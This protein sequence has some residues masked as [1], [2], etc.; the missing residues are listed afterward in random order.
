MRGP[1]S[2]WRDVREIDVLSRLRLE[3][4]DRQ[5][6]Q[7]ER[8]AQQERELTRYGMN[9]F[10]RST[11]ELTQS[12]QG[13]VPDDYQ[14]VPGD[15]I[16]AIFTNLN[17]GSTTESVVIDESGAANLSA[18]G[19]LALAGLTRAHA[20]SALNSALASTRLR[21]M[22]A[23]IRVIEMQKIR[24]FVVGEA[25][26]PGGYLLNTSSTVLDALLRAGGPTE[27]GSFRKIQL[28]RHGR[29][30]AT[31]DLYDLLMRGRVGSPRLLQG[32]RVFIP[33]AGEQIS[34]IGEVKRPAIYE[35]KSER[36][37]K[38]A[39]ALAG[40]LLPEAYSPQ[41][42]IRRISKNNQR[43]LLDVPAKGSATAIMP[44]DVIVVRSVLDDLS[45]G[46][47]LSGAV[48]RPGW[49]QLTRGMT[50]SELVRQA[51]GMA[52]GAFPGHAELFRR[53]T[54]GQPLQMLG[55]D[56]ERALLGDPANDLSLK[57]DDAI[58]VYDRSKALAE[59]RVRIQGQVNNPGE[60]PYHEQM[61][62]RDLIL[63]AGGTR[64]EAA[65]NAEIARI[66]NATGR[67]ELLPFNLERALL[68]PQASDNF[69]LMAGDAVVVRPRLHGRSFPASVALLGEFVNPGVYYIN[70]GESLESVI[71]RAGGLTAEA[72]PP[73]AVFTRELPEVMPIEN[74]EVTRSV[75][76]AIREVARQFSQ[77]E[78]LR[79]L[80]SRSARGMDLTGLV[81]DTSTVDPRL[82][83]KLFR[84]GRIPIDL[85]QML[86]TKAGD[87]GV[88]D[89]DVLLVP[90]KPT[91]VA[92]VGAVALPSPILWREG[93]SSDFY[94]DR[95]GGPL[96]DA[97][98][99]E[100]MVMR[101]NGELIRADRA[102]RVD[103]GDVVV[104]PNQAIVAKPDAFERF[105]SVLQ[106]LASGAF[107]FR[108]FQ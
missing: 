91:T 61:R 80:D 90:I 33:L 19:P 35:L 5:R 99:D 16:E 98:L 13:T 89:G 95:A 97:E 86:Q 69:A 22:K 92:V 39:L 74:Q 20:E 52:A 59:R 58:V 103:P 56:L 63:L 71:R 36:S 54:P 32:D 10:N 31:L 23:R 12:V 76:E 29:V 7:E 93:Q 17:G 75:L 49:Y 96:K 108:A 66:A 42:Q 2:G 64:L 4:S 62:V 94:I 77:A 72:Y 26:R 30:V 82:I 43:V 79:Q 101:A 47:Y 78:A 6:A 11:E 46:V 14:L 53:D 44:G 50:I 55:F 24:V 8:L 1:N 45:N 25:L 68:S 27:S 100:V 85:G 38:D 65:P 37:L 102:S 105:L 51:Q 28:Q 87:P 81:G 18:V 106:A 83:E 41:A 40:G 3:Q 70:P 107:L 84:T 88:A 57:P 34:V 15:E 21:N 73:A 48:K 104:V 9:F 67:V 60:Y